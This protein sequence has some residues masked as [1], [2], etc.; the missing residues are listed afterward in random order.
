MP[1]TQVPAA[2]PK[3]APT[4]LLTGATGT[5]GQ[6]VAQALA[7]RGVPFRALVRQPDAPAAQQLAALPGA[8]LVLGDF[9]N[10]ASLQQALAGIERAFLLTNSTEQAEAQ[11]LRFVELARQAGVPRI[12]KLSQWAADAASPVRFLRYHATVEQAIQAAGLAYTFLRPNLFMQGLLAF[13][14]SIQAQGQFFA[15]IGEARISVIDVRDIAAVAAAALTELG[16]ENQVY[17]LTGPAA[18]THAEMAAHLAAAVGYP[19]AFVDV[20]PTALRGYLAQAGF[21]E[22]QIEGLLE[23]Y[24]HY[25]RGEAAVVAAGVQQA[26]GQP[27]RDFAAFARDY[28]SAFR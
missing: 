18:L 9:N 22:W 5:V 13:K 23:D 26:T 15:P 20:P 1:N 21:P 6:A 28:A 17:N 25:H 3:N 2:L 10:P 8:E 7:G 4:I 19:V 24:A 16:H 12:V 27:P 14:A 11:Q